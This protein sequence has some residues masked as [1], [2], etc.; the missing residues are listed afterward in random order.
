MKIFIYYLIIINIISLIVCLT[1]KIAAKNKGWRI[2]ERTLFLLCFIGGVFGFY[3]GMQIFRHKTK[4]S[5]FVIGVPLIG[6]IWAIAVYFA[7]K[8]LP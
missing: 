3:L 5:N 4:H 8:Y 7:I 6:I 1:D 2:P